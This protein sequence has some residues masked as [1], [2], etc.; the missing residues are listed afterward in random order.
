MYYVLCIYAFIQEGMYK[1]A[2]KNKKK[3]LFALHDFGG[4]SWGPTPA[5]KASQFA[6]DS[7]G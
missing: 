1:I 4:Q 2:Q 6:E 5:D 7:Q 3:R